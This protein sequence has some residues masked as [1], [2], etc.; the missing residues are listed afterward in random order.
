MPQAESMYPDYDLYGISDTAYGFLT[1]GC[2]RQCP[3]CIVSKKEGKTSYK[4]ADLSDFWNGQ[5]YIKLL[6][7]NLLASSECENLLQQFIE[8]RAWV[9]ISQGLDV[10]LMTKK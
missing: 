7:P 4:V 9:D 6:D 2:P 10:H 5:R 8:S 1:R 3:F